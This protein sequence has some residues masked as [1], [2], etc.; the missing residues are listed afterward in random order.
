MAFPIFECPTRI[1]VGAGAI[2]R[3]PSELRD[4]GGTKPLLV[5]DPVLA[6]TDAFGIVREVLEEAGLDYAVYR[7]VEPQP[8]VDTVEAAHAH[9]EQNDCDSLL[10]FGGGSTIDTAKGAAILATNG[11]SPRD[12]YGS[13]RYSVA[14]APLV[15]V[16]TTAGTGSEVSSVASIRDDERKAKLSIRHSRLNRARVAILDP[17]VL[18]T[19]PRGVAVTTGMDALT[20]AVESYTSLEATPI[21]EAFS[22]H[23]MELVGLHIRP[24][25]AN[26][27]N[28]DSAEKMLIGSSL[29]AI[30]FSSAGTGNS[31]CLAR[32][33]AGEFGME[34]GMACAVTLPHVVA[35]NSIA[36]PAKFAKVAATLGEDV[37]GLETRDAALASKAI[38]RLCEDLGV[39]TELDGFGVSAGDTSRIAEECMKA[40]YNRWN[41]RL[42][43]Q[44]DFEEL[45]ARMVR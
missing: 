19:L 29:A 1:L 17:E 4:V 2:R 39:P 20:H 8:S 16:P 36:D 28:R 7:D 11:G 22:L 37:S 33:L 31:H 40:N 42:M 24:F 25:M 30:A 41:P 13:D 10:A 32:I 45:L 9:Y 26:R 27:G 43:T 34:H 15:A 23:A 6:G 44:P 38:F 35:F 21:T 18:R 3:V 5:T 12:Y 14:P